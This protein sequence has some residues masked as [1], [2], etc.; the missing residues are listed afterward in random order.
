[1]PKNKYDVFAATVVAKFEKILEKFLDS[2]GFTKFIREH[3]SLHVQ[4]QKG[5]QRRE[6][7]FVFFSPSRVGIDGASFNA[8]AH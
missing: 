2:L 3:Q 7:K 4:L 1:M 5:L 8:F 6:F